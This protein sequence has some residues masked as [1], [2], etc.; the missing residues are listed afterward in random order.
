MFAA[1]ILLGITL[2]VN[3]AGAFILQRASAGLEGLR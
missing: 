3:M 2:L 1:L